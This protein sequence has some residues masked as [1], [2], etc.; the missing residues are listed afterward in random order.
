[1]LSMQKKTGK[2][3]ICECHFFK[4]VIDATI[5]MEILLFEY[6]DYFCLY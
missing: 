5:K 2:T 4:D 6:T 3:K 1:M